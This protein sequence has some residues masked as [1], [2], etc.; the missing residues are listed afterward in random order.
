MIHVYV[1]PFVL[2]LLG[3]AAAAQ[4]DRF[5]PSG[6]AVT[7]LVTAVV[8]WWLLRGKGIIRPHTRILVASLVGA[9]GIAAW[10]GL[11]QLRLEDALWVYLPEWLRPG[12]R[13]GLNP[14]EVFGAPAVAWAYVT[15]RLFGLAVVVPV[16]EELFWRGF[17]L[18]WLDGDDWEKAP[19]G[20]FSRRSFLIVTILF[21]LAHP[22]W[23]AAALYCILLNSLMY[24]KRDLW[25][26]VV[27]HGV[28][29]L[30]LG[31]YILI[32]EEWLW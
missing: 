3:T 12:A 2:Y 29:N 18:R 22:E 32:S 17:M 11:S 7:A 26:C 30:I 4:S 8:A 1:T 24:W 10:I 5:G 31:F 19:L 14:F 21:T 6:Y 16:A 15:V 27:A 28:S 23:F 13:V 9:V 25:A 20:H